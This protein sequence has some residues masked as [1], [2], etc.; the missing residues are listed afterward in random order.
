MEKLSTEEPALDVFV[1]IIV[2]IDEESSG[3]IQG[4]EHKC[5]RKNQEKTHRTA[6]IINIEHKA[7]HEIYSIKDCTK[8]KTENE[9]IEIIRRELGIVENDATIWSKMIKAIDQV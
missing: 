8:D 6:S 5:E 7:S 9:L 2:N 3:L 4:E 1:Q